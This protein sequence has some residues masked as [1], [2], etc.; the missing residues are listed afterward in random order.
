VKTVAD[1]LGVSR[2]NLV[3]QLAANAKSA[4]RWKRRDDDELLKRI[5]AVVDERGSYGYRRTTTLVNRQLVREG[6][7]TV[8][9]KRVYRV[10]REHKLLL[11]RYTGKSTRTHDGVI[12]TLKS[13]LRWCSDSFEIRCWNGERIQVAFSLDCCDR[14]AMRYVATTGGIS[15]EMIRDLM[16]ETLEHRFGAGVKSAPHPIEWLSDNGHRTPLARRAYSARPWA[17]SSAPRRPT[18]RSRTEWPKPS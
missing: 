12:I 2:S 10:M 7:P 14:E 6:L 4:K 17:F 9:H 5:R 3:K 8:N 16:A 13:N 18:R 1:A 11:Q 15:G